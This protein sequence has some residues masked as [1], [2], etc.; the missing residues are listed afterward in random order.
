MKLKYFNRIEKI[1]KKIESFTKVK[2][3]VGWFWSDDG[4][5]EALELFYFE[6]R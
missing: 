2:Y 5:L 1:E 4:K 3:G 6:E